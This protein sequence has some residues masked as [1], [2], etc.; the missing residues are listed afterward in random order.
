MKTIRLSLFLLFALLLVIP[1]SASQLAE[2]ALRNPNDMERLLRGGFDIIGVTDGEMVE[3]ILHNQLERERLDQLGFRYMIT[4]DDIESYIA[5]YLNPRGEPRRDPMGPYRTFDEIVE[6]LFELHEEYSDIFS[7]PVSI[8]ESIEGRD[9]WAVKISDNPEEDEDEP[10][11]LLTSLIHAREPITGE[12]IF[13]VMHYLVENYGEDERVTMLVDERQIWFIPCH[14]PDGWVYN[15][16]EDPEGGG[17]WRKNR[18]DNEDGSYGVDLN[19]NWGYM[20]GFDN[21]GSSPD[22][23][24]N[25]YRGEGPFSE[26]ETQAAREFINDHNFSISIYFHSWGNLVLYPLGYN[27]LYPEDRSLLD[28]LG[29]RMAI[30]NQYQVGTGWEIIYPTNGDS[31]DWLYM[32]DEHDPIMAFTVEVGPR[33]R[34][35]VESFWPPEDLIPELVSENLET[36]L[37]VAEYCDEPRRILPPPQPVAVSAVTNDQDEVVL[38]WEAPDD[39]V[40]PA[41]SYN[42]RAFLPDEPYIDDAGEEQELWEFENSAFSWNQYHSEPTSY[43][44]RTTMER[45]TLTLTDEIQ[46]PDTLWAWV[47]YRLSDLRGHGVAL[48]VSYDGYD[49]EPLH[50][51]DTEDLIRNRCN[52]GPAIWGESDGWER[53]CW[54][55]REHA[56]KMVELRF[57]YYMFSYSRNEIFYIDDIGPLPGLQDLELIAEDVENLFCVDRDH[58]LDDGRHYQ[59]QAIDADGDLSFWSDPAPVEAGPSAYAIDIRLGWSI[60]SSPLAPVEPALEDVFNE[61]SAKEILLLFK[62][63]RGGF[64]VPRHRFNSIGD[65]NPLKGYQIKLAESAEL[66]MRGYYLDEDTPIYLEDRW[67]LISYLPAQRMSAEVALHSVSDNLILVKDGSGHFWLPAWEFNNMRPMRRGEGYFIFMEE[68]DTLIYPVE[69]DAYVLESRDYSTDAAGFSPPGPDNHSLLLLFDEPLFD[70]IISLIDN[71]DNLCGRIGTETGQTSI[72]IAA[73]GETGSD[74]CGYKNKEVFRAYWQVEDSGVETALELSLISGDPGY[75]KNGLTVMTAALESA[76]VPL[77]HGVISVYPNPFN[78][79]T[80]M[81]F[82]L[83]SQS[84]ITLTLY[85]ANGRLIEEIVSGSYKSG[86]HRVVWNGTNLPSGLYLGRLSIKSGSNV[87][88]SYTK[89][90]LMR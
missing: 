3:I 62:D 17:M 84:D 9:L 71:E 56:G 31:D 77:E 48:E 37:T 89:L 35:S 28:A 39:E 79:S 81:R 44:I 40:N 86:M 47:N 2:V 1:V 70:G 38:R 46:A 5:S 59:V 85:D 4:L 49:W 65:W 68:R 14:N 29:K 80:T 24:R 27:Y 23:D 36:C 21:I 42:V 55:L 60:I 54:Y 8:G 72:G 13:A 19:R 16:E 73:W 20:W 57:R 41:V 33:G 6:E 50:G 52:L 32:S 63:D 61:F 78:S 10:E 25:T 58:G 34:T 26:P 75:T 83:V 15:E 11:V 51:R 76:V 90:L 7:E 82:S 74:Q 18:R 53:T 66:V 67:S 64:F 43:R 45:S 22:P 87:I 88:Y 12:I 69:R 30:E